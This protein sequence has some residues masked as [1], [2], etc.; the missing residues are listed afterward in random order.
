MPADK[1]P[2]PTS[3]LLLIIAW[4]VVGIPTAW[5][6]SQMVLRSLDL[7]TAPPPASASRP[8]KAP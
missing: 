4:L 3:H 7:F 1:P 6:V 8:A 2:R 5:G